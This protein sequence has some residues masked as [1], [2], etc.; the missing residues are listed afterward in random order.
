MFVESVQGVFYNV[1][2]VLDVFHH[3]IDTVGVFQD[4]HTLG[5]GVVPYCEWMPNG[6]GKL[7]AD[8]AKSF[9][10]IGQVFCVHNL[11]KKREFSVSI[12]TV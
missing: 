4:V 7:P 9:I 12:I 5:V 1:Q 8:T 6:L 11:K 2:L 3:A 10:S